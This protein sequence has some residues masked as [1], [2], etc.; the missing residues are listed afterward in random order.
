MLRTLI[1]QKGTNWPY[2][3]PAIQLNLN[4]T[5]KQGHEYSPYEIIFGKQA[6]LPLHQPIDR[7]IIPGEPNKS[8]MNNLKDRIKTIHA[9]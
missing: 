8:Y 3:L 6:K 1:Q 4:T 9:N 2:F 5:I 7:N